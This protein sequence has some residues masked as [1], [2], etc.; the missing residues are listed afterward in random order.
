[1]QSRG[2]GF[3]FGKQ[4]TRTVWTG[5]AQGG[6]MLSLFEGRVRFRD[7]PEAACAGVETIGVGEDEPFQGTMVLTLPDGSVSRQVFSGR[8][9]TRDSA[10]RLRGSGLWRFGD[11][12]GQFARLTGGGSFLWWLDGLDYRA[13]FDG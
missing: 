5:P 11:G 8:V 9:E 3:R 12:S 13:E 2:E 1:M 10:T 7:G 4:E 6:L